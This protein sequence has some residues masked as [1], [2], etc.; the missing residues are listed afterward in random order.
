MEPLF[1]YCLWI[2][3]RLRATHWAWIHLTGALG[4]NGLEMKCGVPSRGRPGN[5]T[6]TLFPHRCSHNS[7]WN[8]RSCSSL[9][10][11]QRELCGCWESQGQ[12]DYEQTWEQHAYQLQQERQFID[13]RIDFPFQKQSR[14]SSSWWIVSKGLVLKNALGLDPRWWLEALAIDFASLPESWRAVRKSLCG[15]RVMA[16]SDA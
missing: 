12:T 16:S 14:V 8:L 7:I 1:V 11:R 4:L 3:Y 13:G 10:L 5:H 6:H 15:V 9:D 2:I